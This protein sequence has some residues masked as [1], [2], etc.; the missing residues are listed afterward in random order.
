MSDYEDKPLSAMTEDERLC[1]Y[2]DWLKLSAESDSQQRQR[3]REDL[4]FQIPENQWPNEAKQERIG[5][6][7]LSISLLHQ[8]MQLVQ[9]QAAQAHLGVELHPVSENADKELAE[10]KQGLYMRIQRDGM[11]D[12]ARLWA[13]DRA[14]QCGRGWY[15]ILTQYDEDSDNPTD[16]E[17]VYQRILY[18]EMVFPDPAAQKPDFSDGR[19]MFIGAYWPFSKIKAVYPKAKSYTALAFEGIDAGTPDWIREGK[20]ALI[21]ECFYIEP[22]PDGQPK[23][24]RAVLSACEI[25]EE[26]E[27]PGRYIPVV[28]VIGR[29]LQ[30]IDGQR[31]WEG[32]VRPA[33]DGQM[34][35]NYAASTL[36]ERMALEPKTPFIGYE[37][38]FDGHKEEWENV[39]RRNF[40]YIEVRPV[41]DQTNQQVLP[42]PQRAQIDQSGMSLALLALQQG[43]EFVQAAT[44]VYE[45]SLGETPKSKDAQSGRAILALQQQTDAGTSNY[46]QN[47]KDISLP[48]DAR[49]VLDL[50]PI[51]Y[52]RPG[53]VTQILTGEDEP[54]AVMLNKPYMLDENGRPIAAADP[55]QKGVKQ[56]TLSG[57]KYAI[58]ASVG[59]SHQTRLEQGQ[60]FLQAVVQ[61]APELMATIGDLV[62]KFRDEPGAKEI[63][64]RLKRLIQSTQPGLIEDDD[65]AENAKAQ[66]Q[67]LKGQVQQLT[68]QLQEAA[69]IIDNEQVKQQANIVI[70][71]IKAEVEK[72]GIAKDLQ[73]AE[74][75]NAAKLAVERVKIGGQ[76]IT[77][78]SEMAE[79]REA[80]GLQI[81]ADFAAAE[82]DRD[83]QR[84]M[85]GEKQAHDVGMAAGGAN[86]FQMSREG[87]QETG[88]EQ[89]QE[90][91]QGAS[92]ESSREQST[93]PQADGSGD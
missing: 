3:E 84:Q 43:R 17:I 22:V 5:R 35:F 10:I 93:Q 86:K 20:D 21:V 58:V 41:I 15:R 30:P 70:A 18:Q 49:I 88:Q 40:P 61:A 64:D 87:G 12:Q 90:Q 68:Q 11:A 32:M 19:F 60:E 33:R 74:M 59:K 14:K 47:L 80:T 92:K 2:K 72:A 25:L 42:L 23:I 48:L 89:S 37:G 55:R 73:I 13:L 28:P 51:I 63:A 4:L 62:F 26:N 7:M 56:H 45:P 50:M 29:E 6:P 16:Q 24:L 77:K 54:R 76:I 27:W 66:A 82:A 52:D 75:N 46:L 44:A 85:Q 9:N 81:A 39:N 91:S 71:Q 36:V 8:P 83:H 65:S 69:K 79:E 53:R 78:Q 34:L 38:Q 57:G 31:R 1:Q 67:A